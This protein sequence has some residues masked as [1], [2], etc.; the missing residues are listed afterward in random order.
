MIFCLKEGFSSPGQY[1][2]ANVE[3]VQLEYGQV[4]WYT[5]CVDLLKS[6]IDK[7]NYSV[8]ADNTDIKKY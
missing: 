7:F 5:N 3:K 8:R 2:G 4:V 6:V 1:L